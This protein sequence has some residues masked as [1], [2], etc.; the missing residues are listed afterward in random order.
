MQSSRWWRP[1]FTLVWLLA[2]APV[3]GFDL[4]DTAPSHS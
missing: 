4:I 2:A 3:Q 1:A